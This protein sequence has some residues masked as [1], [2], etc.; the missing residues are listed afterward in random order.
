MLRVVC[1]VAPPDRRTFEISSP[2]RLS[3]LLERALLLFEA[4][5]TATGG[6]FS[7]TELRFGWSAIDF[8]GT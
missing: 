5:P 8:F 1:T 6:S 7:F 4:A 2:E 3:N